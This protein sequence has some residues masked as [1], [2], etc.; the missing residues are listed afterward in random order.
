MIRRNDLLGVQ[1]NSPSPTKPRS[2]HG[3]AKR[4][5][6][7]TFGNTGRLPEFSLKDKIIIV[8]GAGRGLGLVQSEA[9]LEAGAKGKIRFQVQ[10]R[11]MKNLIYREP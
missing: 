5:D 1:S 7:F 9:L 11:G 3:T 10:P 2:F 4:L 6:R 8:S